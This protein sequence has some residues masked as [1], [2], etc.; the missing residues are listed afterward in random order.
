MVITK[1]LTQNYT[2]DEILE[3]VKFPP[4][5]KVDK[6]LSPFIAENIDEALKTFGGSR[7]E[8]IHAAAKR[9]R[10]L[11]SGAIPMV[12][13]KHRNIVTAL[14]EIEAGKVKKNSK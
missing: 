1:E 12:P 5:K 9:V 6:A 8:L 4:L 14:L 10:E 3:K 13:S 7:F 2:I 11:T